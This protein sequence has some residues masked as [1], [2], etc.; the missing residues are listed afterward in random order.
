MPETRFVADVDGMEVPTVLTTPAEPQA[1][2]RKTGQA[3]ASGKCSRFSRA[4]Q[5]CVREANAALLYAAQPQAEVARFLELQHFYKRVP[6]GLT[7]MESFQIST[8]SDPAVAA[9]VAAWVVQNTGS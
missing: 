9:T 1:A 7:P 5:R 4:R 3:T 8:E 6:P 2:L